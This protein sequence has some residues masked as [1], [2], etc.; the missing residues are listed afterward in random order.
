[1]SL[2]GDK[3]LSKRLNELGRIDM[4][5]AVAN[6]IQAVRSEAVLLCPVDHGELRQSIMTDVEERG[7]IV[8]GTCYT[9][10]A[11]AVYVEFGTGPKGMADHDGVSPDVPVSYSMSPWWIHESM[12]DKAAAEKYHWLKI[13]TKSGVF[14]KCSGQ[15]AQPFMYPALKNN[16]K[17]L[18][19]GIKA[20]FRTSIE[21]IIK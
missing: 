9:N 13:E 21:E 17:R 19:D 18:V 8:T 4:R 12:V 10:K 2:T 1:M 6:G 14:Y 15:A 16:R 7:G 5:Q 20:D 3:E 11:Y